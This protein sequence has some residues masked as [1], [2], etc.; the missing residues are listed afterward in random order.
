MKKNNFKNIIVGNGFSAAISKLIIE[1]DSLVIGNFDHKIFFNNKEFIRRENIE[2]NKFFSKK[3][4]SFGSLNFNLFKGVF[5]D[6]FKIGGNSNIWGGHINLK[7]FSNKIIYFFKLKGISFQK[8]DFKTTG[9]KTNNLKIK[10]MQNKKNKILNIDDLNIKIKNGFISYFNSKNGKIFLGI[11]LPNK[12]KI[13]QITAKRI[14]LCTG[15]IQLLDLLYRSKLLKEGDLIE[16]SEFEHKFVLRFT[17][18]KFEKNCTT[19]RYHISRSI[20]HFLGLQY[21]SNFL[22]LLNFLPICIDQNFYKK[23]KKIKLILKNNTLEEYD[24]NNNSHSKFG[25]SIHYCDLKINGIKINNFLKKINPNIYGFGM[26]FVNQTDPGPI[27]ND[28]ILD[29]LK[30]SKKLKILGL[31]ENKQ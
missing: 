23:K 18:S 22:K 20:G 21:F 12:K 28:I 24:F 25:D 19:I 15:T 7:K 10:Q 4:F 9:T 27:S 17:F 30:K 31:N 14:F 16:Y 13:N 8:L 29:I 11:Q 5:H 26:S 6:H 1:K 2:C 3:A